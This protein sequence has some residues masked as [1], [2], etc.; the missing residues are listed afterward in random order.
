MNQYRSEWKYLCTDGQLELLKSRLNG[1]L[2]P[3]EHA[4]DSHAV[5]SNGVYQV[6]S[7]YFDDYKNSCAAGNE[8]GDGIRFKYRA[9]FYNDSLSTMHLERKEKQYGLGDKKTC[10]LTLEEYN[11]LLTGDCGTTFWETDKPLLKNF[12]VQV[13]MRGFA[14]K[15][16]IDYERTAFVCGTNH[17]YPHYA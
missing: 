3:D 13:M 8:S 10:S 5:D 15:A 9:R 14:P 7:L 6:H 12:C 2:A 11:A 4:V 1:I 17:P 16:V